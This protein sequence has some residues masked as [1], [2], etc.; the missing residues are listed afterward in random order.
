[1]NSDWRENSTVS[2]PGPRLCFLILCCC[3]LGAQ[4]SAGDAYPINICLLHDVMDELS[5]CTRNL[6]KNGWT[7]PGRFETVMT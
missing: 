3:M 4:H 2:F 5:E 7:K 6:T 1:M